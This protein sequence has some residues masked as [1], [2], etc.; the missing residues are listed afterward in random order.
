MLYLHELLTETLDGE[1]AREQLLDAAL[2]PQ[3][4]GPTLAP[5]LREHLAQLPARSSPRG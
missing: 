3:D 1:R 4:I 2:R 5:A